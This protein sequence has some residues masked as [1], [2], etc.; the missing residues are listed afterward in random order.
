MEREK[1]VSKIEE[2][3]IDTL[4]KLSFLFL[5]P[6]EGEEGSTQEGTIKIKVDF[7]GP[8]NGYMWVAVPLGA[9]EEIAKNML[10]MD[11]A[12]D[13][14]E[15]EDALKE[16]ANVL[17][18]NIL[19]ELFGKRLI[20]RIHMPTVI[21]EDI[22]GDPL[23]TVVLM[24]ELEDGGIMQLGFSFHTPIEEMRVGEGL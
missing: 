6:L 24:F 9:G 18:G 13:S 17:C 12:L 16:C 14:K 2:V 10:G 5:N 11:D 22:Q 21:S 7:E 8:Y 15:V 23:R 3:T 19:P 1:I 4:E 20:F